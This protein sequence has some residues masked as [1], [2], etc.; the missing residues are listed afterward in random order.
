MIGAWELLEGLAQA[1]SFAGCILLAVLLPGLTP[2]PS[3]KHSLLFVLA[4]LLGGIAVTLPFS[5][6]DPCYS[7]A[8][9]MLIL[10]HTFLPVVLLWIGLVGMGLFK[11]LCKKRQGRLSP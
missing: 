8:D 2:L 5:A 4:F 7:R 9:Y 1:A 6:F 10:L 3:M 11:S